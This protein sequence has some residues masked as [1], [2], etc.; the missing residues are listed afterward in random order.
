[1]GTVQPIEAEHTRTPSW[2]SLEKPRVDELQREK[3]ACGKKQ[4]EDERKTSRARRTKMTKDLKEEGAWAELWQ[5]SSIRTTMKKTS[6]RLMSRLRIWT[7]NWVEDA[8]STRRAN[9]EG[10]WGTGIDPLTLPLVV[11]TL[12]T[13]SRPK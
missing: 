12:R 10:A 1:M 9:E 6:T 4:Q 3:Y 7:R 2:K 8:Q 11:Q 5:R 13:E